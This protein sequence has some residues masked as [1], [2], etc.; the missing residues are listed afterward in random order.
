MNRKLF[1]TERDQQS[2]PLLKQL[3]P[4]TISRCKVPIYKS[5]FFDFEMRNLLE[6]HSMLAFTK[7]LPSSETIQAL[8]R[9]SFWRQF[10]CKFSQPALSF[11]L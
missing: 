4:I 2:E 6:Y 8:N 11:F 3:K 7:V 9:N 5:C 1:F 10:Y